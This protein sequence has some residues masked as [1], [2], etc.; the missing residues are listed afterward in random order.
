MST[1]PHT[2]SMSWRDS[3]ACARQSSTGTSSLKARTTS[4][5]V[6]AENRARLIGAFLFTSR[7]S[8]AASLPMSSPSRSKSVAITIS[9]DLRAA[10]LSARISSRSAG[11]LPIGAHT[12][13]GS[14]A[15]FQP[16]RSTPSVVKGFFLGQGGVAS[17]AGM[18]TGAF[19][20][21]SSQTASQEPSPKTICCGK[22]TPSTW[23]L[24]PML[25]HSSPS[26]SKV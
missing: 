9:S 11:V 10:L 4:P 19:I 23:P 17:D 14:D 15:S 8:A 24:R 3:P 26:R 6:S 7:T 22:S 16:F 5:L 12:R 1:A 21:S 13:Y 20:A 25:I 2:R 18:T